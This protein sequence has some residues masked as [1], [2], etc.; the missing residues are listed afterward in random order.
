MDGMCRINSI[1]DSNKRHTST[2]LKMA[3]LAGDKCLNPWAH[4]GQSTCKSQPLSDSTRGLFTGPSYF[5]VKC[6]STQV[7]T[8]SS[9][10]LVLP[11]ALNSLASSQGVEDAFIK[12]VDQERLVRKQKS[13][14]T[15]GLE[16][17]GSSGGR[18]AREAWGSLPQTDVLVDLD[19]SLSIWSCFTKHR[20][21]Y[22]EIL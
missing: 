16:E 10:P 8:Y 9:H 4:R 12:S 22:G 20:N 21:G 5:K 11:M 15:Q 6:I 7:T 14:L 19:R 3:P 2:L 17:W 1:D 13:R 18:N